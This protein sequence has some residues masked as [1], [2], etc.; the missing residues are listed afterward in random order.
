[1]VAKYIF[2]FAIVT[3]GCKEANYMGFSHEIGILNTIFFFRK[4]KME[5]LL[6]KSMKSTFLQ[7][8][9]MVAKSKISFAAMI[10]GCKVKI[11]SK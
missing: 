2:P 3:D 1:M 7:P 11:I 9:V 8:S 4:K 5:I 6:K 10:H